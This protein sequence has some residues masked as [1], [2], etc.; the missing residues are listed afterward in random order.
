MNWSNVQD[1][2]IPHYHIVENSEVEDILKY[3]L[4]D[5]LSTWEFYKKSKEQVS[6]RIALSKEYNLSLMNA[7]APKI[8]AE[9]FASIISNEMN[10][11]VSE[12]KEMRTKRDEIVFSDLIFPYIKFENKEFQALLEFLKSCRIE[13]SVLKGFFTD[14]SLNKVKNLLPYFNR[15][16]I[17]K[18]KSTVDNL[19]IIF[20]GFQYDFGVGGIHGCISPGIYESC[21]KFIIVDIDVKN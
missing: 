12:L 8:G 19:H 9:I 10:I 18:K 5:V 6:M 17:D 2:P 16:L 13:G 1:M 4:N 14:I 3:N 15:N 20:E 11:S 21:D 7:N